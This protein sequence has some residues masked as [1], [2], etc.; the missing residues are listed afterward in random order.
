MEETYYQKQN[1]YRKFS[2]EVSSRG[3]IDENKVISIQLTF[4]TTK[5][6]TLAKQIILNSIQNRV[7]PTYTLCLHY[8][9]HIEITE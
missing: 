2:L 3:I 1:K 6:D 9:V 7:F 5:N 8:F 4:I